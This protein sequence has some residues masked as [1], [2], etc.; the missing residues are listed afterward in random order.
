MPGRGFLLNNEMTDFDFAPATPGTYD[1]NIAAPGKRPRSSMS[2]TI[3]LKH[4]RFDF[5]IGSPGGST[6]IT[7]VL[8]ILI[9]H[10]D[11]GMSLPQAIW[12]P[13]ASQ[14]NATAT[15]AEKA[16]ANSAVGKALQI[17]V[18]R[19]VQRA[20]G[21][22]TA[23]VIG[24]ATGIQSL[25]HGRYQAAAEKVREGGG[26]A[27]V[28]HPPAADQSRA[29][30]SFPAAMTARRMGTRTSSANPTTKKIASDTSAPRY[31]PVFW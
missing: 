18:R 14:R 1:P 3:V 24:N 31:E 23:Q 4:G 28:V 26:S 16:F 8:Q 22:A 21:A 7:T 13:R 20:E 19:V 25:G 9:N 30:A 5:A 10:V 17:E 11:F 12:A 6:I 27:L 29:G 2:P 15:D